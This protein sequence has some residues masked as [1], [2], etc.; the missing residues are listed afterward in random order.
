[1]GVRVRSDRADRKENSTMEITREGLVATL[2][3]FAIVGI[4]VIVANAPGKR[5]DVV[6]PSPT[7]G[8]RTATQ[9]PRTTY[10]DCR[11]AQPPCVSRVGGGTWLLTESGARIPVAVVGSDERA[12]PRTVTIA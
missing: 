7:S 6:D 3:G 1:V 4:V 10:P 2:A 11:D 12:V 9:G 5:V 8:L